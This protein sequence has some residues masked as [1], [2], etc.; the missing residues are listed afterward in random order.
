MPAIKHG[1]W[2]EVD[3]PQVNRDERNE[4][5]E[6]FQ[7]QCRGLP[8]HLRDLER[9]AQFLDGS[10]A[11]DNLTQ[12]FD[13]G[14]HDLSGA[15]DR[16]DWR[17]Q[18]ADALDHGFASAD[19]QPSDTEF[20]AKAVILHDRADLGAHLQ[21]LPVPLD[22]DIHRFTRADARVHD[23]VGIGVHRTPVEGQDAV[24]D[25]DPSGISGAALFDDARNRRRTAFAM[26]E[27]EG[28]D[29]QYGEKE[30]DRRPC[31]NDGRALPQWL[32]GEAF[33]AIAGRHFQP[34]RV[35]HAGRVHIPL[36]THIAAQGQRRD[37]P[38]GAAPVHPGEEFGTEADREGLRLHSEP[39]ADQI[40]AKLMDE[41]QRS[42]DRHK[43]QHCQQEAGILDQTVNLSIV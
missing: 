5:D 3:E 36:E 14:P 30:I 24:T 25:L 2:Q 29:D 17:A 13:H 10:A 11:T 15:L 32:G 43:G 34:G 1:N 19:T 41:D 4:E 8:R 20:L 7:P 27:G 23:H 42:D 21:P 38:A 28:R 26:D 18:Q 9:P 33:S 12:S 40:M 35:G 16:H 6:A 37:A 22:R 31:R 39:A